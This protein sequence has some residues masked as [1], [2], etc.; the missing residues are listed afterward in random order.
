MLMASNPVEHKNKT[1]KILNS[2]FDNDPN[3]KECIVM[4]ENKSDCNIIVRMEGVGNTKYR[5][6]V[7]AHGDNSVV[8]EKEIIFYK[9]GLRSTV[10]ITE[11]CSKTNYG[12]FKQP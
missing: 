12:G 1:V 3:A 2:L 7:P 9:L 8:I 6:A 11:N 4:I 5:L 10:C